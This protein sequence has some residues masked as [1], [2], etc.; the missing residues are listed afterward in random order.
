MEFSQRSA[1]PRK[2][3]SMFLTTNFQIGNDMLED[4]FED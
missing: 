2:G 4:D 1:S 3:N